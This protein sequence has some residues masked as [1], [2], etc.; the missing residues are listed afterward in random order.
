MLVEEITEKSP[1][2]VPAPSGP[3]LRPSASD[4]LRALAAEQPL[5]RGRR[6]ASLWRATKHKGRRPQHHRRRPQYQLLGAS[7]W[8]S[9]SNL[10]RLD[11]PHLV[12]LELV[13]N[14]LVEAFKYSLNEGEQLSR[15]KG[16]GQ[17]R[18]HT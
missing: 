4:P 17:I 13:A 6:R 2:E 18:T 5:T 11:L 8:P 15:V 1:C 9:S 12:A 14:A 10:A 3:G 7:V 16:L